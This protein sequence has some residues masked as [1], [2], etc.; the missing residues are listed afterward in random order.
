MRIKMKEQIGRIV[1]N[2]ITLIEYT[3]SEA[4][5]GGRFFI[6]NGAMGIYASEKELKDLYAVLNYYT[7]IEEIHDCKVKIEGEDVAI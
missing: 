3:D 5:L 1:K 2:N 7:N 6:Q 4:S